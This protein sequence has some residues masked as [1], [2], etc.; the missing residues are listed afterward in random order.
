M[1]HPFHVISVGIEW[2]GG[3]KVGTSVTGVCEWFW[4]QTPVTGVCVV[5]G[6]DPSYRCVSVNMVCSFLT[7]LKAFTASPNSS[8]SSSTY[9]RESSKDHIPTV[10]Y[11]NTSIR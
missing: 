2:V 8:S 5:L 6:P 7:E 1:D 9:W 3:L 4:V 11:N 10:L